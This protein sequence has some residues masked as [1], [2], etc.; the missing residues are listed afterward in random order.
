M[1]ETSAGHEKTPILRVLWHHPVHA[2]VSLVIRWVVGITFLVA[3]WPKLLAPEDFAWS[4]ALYR[5][6]PTQYVHI[7]AIWLPMLELFAAAL[8]LAGWRVRGAAV[9]MCGMLV[10][11]IIALTYAHVHQIE[12]PTCGCF[13]PAGARALA[14][15]G[16]SVGTGL[17][18]RDA[19]MLI[20]CGYVWLF[21]TGRWGL[22]G[23]LQHRRRMRERTEKKYE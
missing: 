8:F 16:E 15:H 21:D 6:L 9:A 18:W 2:A 4:V 23:F 10:M 20:A 22:D 5:M 19:A 1:S 13:T 17:L 14:E 3:A 7:L 12:M 11:F